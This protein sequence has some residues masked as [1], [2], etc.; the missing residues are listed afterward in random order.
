MNFGSRPEFPDLNPFDLDPVV[1]SNDGSIAEDLG[2]LTVNEADQPNLA[3]DA[4]LQI[5]S[6]NIQ[7]SGEFQEDAAFLQSTDFEQQSAS[8][9]LP[10]LPVQSLCDGYL[11]P[12]ELGTSLLA[13]FL[14]DWNTAYP[15]YQPHVIADHLRICYAGL[16]DGSAVAWTN[17]YVVFGMAHNLRAM[18]TTGT[19]QDMEMA[20]YYLARLYLGLN[21]LLT[22][23]PSLGQV[24]CLIGVAMLI[25]S[26]P[27]GYNKSEGHFVSTALRIV[28]SLAYC[29][30]STEHIP[31]SHDNSQLLR[32]FWIAFINDSN[33]SILNN[34]AKTYKLEDVAECTNLI[35]DE[36]GTVTA[37]EGNWRVNIFFLSTRLALLQTEAIDQV[38][39]LKPRNTTPLELTAATTIILARLQTFHEQHQVFQLD[40]N[41]LFQLLY[42]SDV[43]HCVLLESMYFA[44]V[45]RLHAFMALDMN[46]KINPFGSEGLRMMSKVKQQKVVREAKRLLNLLSVA[47]RGNIALYW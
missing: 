9:L 31:A 15:L 45:Y 27:C 8:Q 35:S 19:V 28:R 43:V 41:Q 18:S 11:P 26:S 40:A 3:T 1:G 37:A 2:E 42:Q 14:T 17:A 4:S 6:E 5:S 25:M 39:S 20:Q 13:E 22:A 24:Q 36:L 32:A 34:T 29:P 7:P 12:P 10:P 46:A 44:T 21:R 16:S 47:P 23:P 38:L 33:L 30:E